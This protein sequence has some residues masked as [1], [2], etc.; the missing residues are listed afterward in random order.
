MTRMKPEAGKGDDPMVRTKPEAAFAKITTMERAMA[1]INDGTALMYGGFGGIGNP[2]GLIQ[3]ILDKGVKDLVLIGND[4]AFPEVGI[5]RVVAA[6]R[7][8]KLI[9]SHIGSNPAAGTLM[10]AGKLEV[11][12]SPQ[13]T[14][15][16]RIRAAGVGLGGV[17]IDVGLGTI[18][19]E[20][21]RKIEA[22]GRTYLLE[23]PLGADVAIVSAKK[24][25]PFGN[26]VF[27]K[28]ARNFNPLVAMAGRIT[29]AEAEEIVPLGSLNPEEIVTPGV[30]V[31][32][33]VPGKGVNWLWAWE[34]QSGS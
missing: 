2:P 28:T 21:K 18:A 14:L 10:S 32:W 34:K 9:A 29:I 31:D 24:A 5:G 12:F 22:D 1:L 17:L 11:E 19:E 3:G 7:A 13:G 20:G 27:D 30:F 6:G 23:T 33:I 4:A 25:D 26:L 8:R 15:A 16:E